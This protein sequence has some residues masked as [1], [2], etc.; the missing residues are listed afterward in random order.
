MSGSHSP[1]IAGIKNGT[2]RG[3][4]TSFSQDALMNVA[5]AD[6]PAV[7]GGNI[8]TQNSALSIQMTYPSTTDHRTEEYDG[9]TWKIHPL[10]TNCAAGI[11]GAGEVNGFPNALLN[12]MPFKK[13]KLNRKANKKRKKATTSGNNNSHQN[14]IIKNGK[15][16]VGMKTA[17]PKRKILSTVINGTLN[18]SNEGT[19][20]VNEQSLIPSSG[21]MLNKSSLSIPH[22][23]FPMSS[24]TYL[25]NNVSKKRR[26]VVMRNNYDNISDNNNNNRR[27][28]QVTLTNT[29]KESLGKFTKETILHEMNLEPWSI[30]QWSSIKSSLSN[31]EIL[32]TEKSR[33]DTTTLVKKKSCLDENGFLVNKYTDGWQS[34]FGRNRPTPVL[35]WSGIAQDFHTNNLDFNEDDLYNNEVE[36]QISNIS[37]NHIN[38]NVSM[39]KIHFSN[40][41]NNNNKHILK[42]APLKQQR[43]KQR[44][45]LYMEDNDDE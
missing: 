1:Y 22:F 3:D 30:L 44:Q 9:M 35:I 6:G 25:K 2:L 27:K 39:E 42:R 12:K 23:L 37:S 36:S 26:R 21:G 8:G 32:D 10:Q 7:K 40:N 17:I 16:N 34:I 15:N 4:G 29:I 38:E 28:K 24:S 5:Q 13:L 43:S 19:N 20:N 11:A 18:T 33:L 41:N 14:T 31:K 45:A